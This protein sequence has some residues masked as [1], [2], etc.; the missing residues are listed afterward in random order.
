MKRTIMRAGVV[1]AALALALP[2]S[3]LAKKGDRDNDRMP[4]RW[5]AKHHLRTG[6][7][8]AAR[9]PDKDRVSNLKEFRA[10]T[11][12]RRADTDRDGL[13]DDAERRTGNDARDRDTDD[14]GV[15]D[16]D[17]VNGTIASFDSAT[18]TLT[19]NVS[20]GGTLTGLVTDATR[21]ECEGDDDDD[22]ISSS[23]SG[24][25]SDGDGDGSDNSGP[26]SDNSGP[27]STGSDRDDGD[28]DD[29]RADDDRADDRDDDDRDEDRPCTT[30]DLVPGTPVHEAEVEL[31]NGQAVFEE[32]ELLPRPATPPSA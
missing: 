31:R 29:D 11:N 27:G 10:K 20:G 15:R 18:R 14:D 2:G 3:A 28:G 1:A 21:I 32:V 9:D 24:P 6:Q 30:A 13:R 5:E 16:G 8:D 22:R 23:S 25:G 19:I 17:E 4:D 7:N 26:G 12:P